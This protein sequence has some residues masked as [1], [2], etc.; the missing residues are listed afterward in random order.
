MKDLFL[1]IR[2]ALEKGERVVLARILASHGSTPRGE[3]ARMAIFAD[4]SA[5]GTIGG[6]AVEHRAHTLGL[7]VLV[8]GEEKIQSYSLHAGEIA[9]IGMVC[10]GDVLVCLQIMDDIS[11]VDDILLAYSSNR[12]SYLV[13]EVQNGCI[14]KFYLSYDKVAPIRGK[15]YVEQ[16][17]PA[18]RV[19]VFGAGHVSRAL[20]PILSKLEFS[21]VVL[22]DRSSFLTDK[23]FATA[24]ELVTINYEDLSCIDFTQDDYVVIMTRGHSSDYEV[25]RQV[26]KTPV[27]YIGCIGSRAKVAHT[28]QRLREL[29]FNDTDFERIHSPIGLAISAQTPDE[30][31]ISIAAQMIM[32]RANGI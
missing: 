2:R 11:V 13:T 23:L 26:L 18:G 21:C 16:L 4:G 12:S 28:Q 15:V 5:Q 27:R 8:S 14:S 20:V 3:G 22:D 19:F 6:G 10:G 7:D 30:I 24:V 25:L 17:K 31:A 1:N 9:D 32:Q 29:G